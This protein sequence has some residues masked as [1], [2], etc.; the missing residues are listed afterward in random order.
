MRN[1][2]TKWEIWWTGEMLKHHFRCLRVE[3]CF[4]QWTD[5]RW[6]S[7][8]VREREEWMWWLSDGE[9]SIKAQ[10]CIFHSTN[11]DNRNQNELFVFP[12][13]SFSTKKIHFQKLSTFGLTSIQSPIHPRVNKLSTNHS[14]L[15]LAD[16]WL[17]ECATALSHPLNT[18]ILVIP[19]KRKSTCLP[20]SVA[21]GVLKVT[22]SSNNLTTLTTLC[23][24]SKN[25]ST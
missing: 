13:Q 1:E 19:S 12:Q 4:L 18:E 11:K 5:E 17:T 9:N 21:K 20:R 7:V 25:F 8:S 6:C 15:C 3:L 22:K 2:E 24:S 10:R 14:C 23:F 16:N